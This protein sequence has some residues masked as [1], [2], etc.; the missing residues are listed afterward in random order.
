VK[1][2]SNLVVDNFE[3]E[4]VEN[5]RM[6]GEDARLRSASLQW[7]IDSAPYQY[8][9]HF[10]WLGLPI[11][12]FPQDIVAVQEIIWRVRPDVIVETGIA[13]GGSLIFHASMLE[14]LGGDGRVIGVDVDI[15]DHNR[16]AITNH[17]IFKRIS[18]IEG[19]SVA[20]NTVHEVFRSVGGEKRV[21]LILDSNH[22]HDHVLAELKQYSPLVRK[23][24]NII[25]FD[26]II[27]DMPKGYFRNRSWDVGN[28]PRT[29][30]QEFLRVNDRFV[31]DKEMDSKL[32]LSSAPG[33]FLAC[34]KD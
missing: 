28:N 33:G 9:Y 16:A 20:E 17:P 27:E 11:I 1:N 2:R 26:T 21:L 24:G 19:S 4:K 6:Q 13:R 10:T 12:Q 32:L 7:I 30:V 31:V 22:T 18:M 3:D 34:I 29:A 23:G 14:L 15:R 8:C 25:V 5:I